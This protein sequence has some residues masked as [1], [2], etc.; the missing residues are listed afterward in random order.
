VK[1][2]KEKGLQVKNLRT[3]TISRSPCWFSLKQFFWWDFKNIRAQSSALKILLNTSLIQIE[4]L[5]VG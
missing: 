1:F 3:F 5:E 4:F 2:K